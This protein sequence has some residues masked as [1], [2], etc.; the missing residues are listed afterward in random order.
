M[1]AKSRKWGPGMALEE[2]DG[3]A[4]FVWREGD[5]YHEPELLP[6]EEGTPYN[7]LRTFA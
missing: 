5:V 3:A 2:V 4:S 1:D 6:S 7:L